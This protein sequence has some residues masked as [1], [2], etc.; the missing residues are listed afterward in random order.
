MS[1]AP[2]WL[3]SIQ[4]S[5]LKVLA[6]VLFEPGWIEQREISK[7]QAAALRK[8]FPPPRWLCFEAGRGRR[9]VGHY[10]ALVHAGKQA[11]CRQPPSAESLCLF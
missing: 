3:T 4:L 11:S 10:T 1:L 5:P 9:G 8:K 2:S 7:E 6:Q